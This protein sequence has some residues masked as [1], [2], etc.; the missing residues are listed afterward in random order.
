MTLVPK[1]RL[2]LAAEAKGSMLGYVSTDLES[3]CG[4]NRGLGTLN[5]NHAQG[6]DDFE[7]FWRHFVALA[8]HFEPRL[9]LQKHKTRGQSIVD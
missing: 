3:P 1:Q 4:N 8:R 6:I 5:G 2:R 7:C 9:K